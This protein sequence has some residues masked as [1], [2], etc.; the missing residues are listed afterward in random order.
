MRA[1][2]ARLVPLNDGFDPLL[3]RFVFVCECAQLDC[4]AQI[5]LS[6]AEY[7]WVRR[8]P[9][10]FFVLPTPEHVFPDAEAVVERHP[11]YWVVEKIGDAAAVA[12]ANADG[13]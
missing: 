8:N 11:H 5:E 2:N 6:R 3:E 13:H 9:R 4:I 7:E 1:V 10:R 12:E